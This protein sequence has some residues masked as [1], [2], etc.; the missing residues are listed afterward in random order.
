M[1]GVVTED[2]SL[3]GKEYEAMQIIKDNLKLSL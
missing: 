2:E 1:G 3:D